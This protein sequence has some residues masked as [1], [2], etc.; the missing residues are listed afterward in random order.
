MDPERRRR[1]EQ[2][3]DAALTRD[4]AEWPAVLDEQCAGDADLRLVV[5][6][7]LGYV[8][9]PWPLLDS[10]PAMLAGAL[11][12]VAY[13][14]GP[15]LAGRR[16]GAW[17][18][19]REIGRGGM[20]RVF[21]ADRADG[22]FV[23][24]VAIK[25]LRPGLDSEFDLD[26]FRA[27]RQILASLNHP[28][29]ARLLDGGVTEQELP[30]LVLEYVDGQP[31]DRYCNQ[32]DLSTEERVRL[33]LTVAEA[34]QFAHRNLVVHRDLK[35]SNI[36]VAADG[37]VKLLDFGLA[38][39]LEPAAALPS[40]P[41][42]HPGHRWMTPQYAAPEQVRGEPV[43]TLTDVYQLG[44]VLYELLTGALPFGTA[45]TMHELEHAVVHDDPPAPSSLS[46]E[47]HGDLDAIVLKALQKE[48]DQR[49]PSARE[50][51]EDLGNYLSGHPVRARRWTARYRAVRFARRHRGGV[52]FGALAVTLL[53]GGLVREAALRAR[54]EAS[55]RKAEAV[56]RYLVGVFDVADPYAPPDGR[57]GELTVRAMLDRGADRLDSLASQP[58]VEAEVRTVLGRVYTNLGAYDRAVPALRRALEQRR[59]LHGPSHPDVAEAMDQ[60]GVVLLKQDH[61]GEAEPLLREALAQR[62]RL[63]G[64]RDSATT[65]SM[66]H[67]A[68]LLENRNAFA[69]AEPLFRE[70]LA[71]RRLMHGDSALSV[72]TSENNLA[73]FLH[74]RGSDSNAVVLFGRALAIRR[75]TLGVD[76]PL[77]AETVHDLATA[78]EGLGHYAD[79]ERH[80]REALGIQR[81]RLGSAHRSVTMG[82]NDLGQM[83][84]KLSRLEEADS[85]LREALAL[86]RQIFGENHEG[87]SANLSNLA[88]IVRE[89][90]DFERAERLLR[91]ALAIDRHLYGAEHVNVG[92]DLNELGVVLRLKGQPDSAVSVLREALAMSRHLAGDD[93]RSTLAVMIS[94][95]RALRET[96]RFAEA[97]SLFRGALGKLDP[98][99]AE[100]S[101]LV[102][103]GQIGLGRTLTATGRAATA[104]P[105][106]DSAVTLARG[107][108]GP[109][110]WR[111][112]EAELALGE[113]FLRLR[114]RS[115]AEPLLR[116][117]GAVLRAR[118]RAQPQLAA[119][120]DSLLR[121]AKS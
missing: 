86:N 108:L 38:K 8:E 32:R 91:N 3:M 67:V 26:R 40:P 64:E 31:I 80:Y 33:F 76:H 73:R 34:T 4:R 78:E 70:A 109:D 87:V 81:R 24:Q 23:Q 118:R 79:A 54:A 30:Y 88:L 62:R 63:L 41:T 66:D 117:A 35:P 83:L 2:V 97:E 111:T 82:L 21:L 69:E 48:P 12:E 65:A 55:A 27:E 14:T 101:S 17:R 60:L 37:T 84:F 104:V 98:S 71:T 75:R 94:L 25:L 105:L 59:A 95:A 72:A 121:A 18:I 58:E 107:K 57:T 13:Q 92:F 11:A 106:L 120:A 20:A 61:L 50:L 15:D 29:I 51:A 28:N 68:Q 74:T 113:A 110:H 42:T 102:I 7:M 96:G 19:V 44:A 6:E 93:Q 39:L 43:T 16:I 5:E 56:E 9:T 22:H 36:L 99:N 112:A 103:P 116:Q 52:A 47:L 89:R 90:G 10:P 49:Y 45:A 46:P 85:L 115:R 77:T 53:A 119:E 114:Q 100:E 1:V